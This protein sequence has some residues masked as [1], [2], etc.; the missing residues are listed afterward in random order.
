MGNPKQ[1]KW[2]VNP[3]SIVDLTY[4]PTRYFC[5]FFKEY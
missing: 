3:L 5:S 4:Q 1:L 2:D